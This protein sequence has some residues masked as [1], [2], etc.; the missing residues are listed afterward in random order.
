MAVGRT[1]AQFW[2][3]HGRKYHAQKITQEEALARL[4]EGHSRET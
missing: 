1:T 4:E 2:L 3:E